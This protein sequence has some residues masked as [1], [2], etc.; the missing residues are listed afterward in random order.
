MTS[1]GELIDSR[2]LSFHLEDSEIITDIIVIAEILGDDGEMAI[3]VISDE[4][5][6]WLKEFGMLHMALKKVSDEQ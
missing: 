1:L 5:N 2:G 4:H 6:N 3:G